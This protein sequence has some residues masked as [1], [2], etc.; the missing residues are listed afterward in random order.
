MKQNR[1]DFLKA[2]GLAALGAGLVIGCGPKRKGTEEPAGE[3]VEEPV[4]EEPVQPAGPSRM[5]L[6]FDCLF[7]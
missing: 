6:D 4:A 1:R 5:Q 3:P 7:L 2:A